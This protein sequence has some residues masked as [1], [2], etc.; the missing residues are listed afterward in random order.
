MLKRVLRH[1]AVR[2]ILC[3]IGAWYIRLVWS[4]GSWIIENDSLPKRMWAEKKPFIMAFWHGHLLLMPCAWQTGR[5]IHMLISRHRDGQMIS[6]TISHFGLQTVS[7]SSGKGGGAAVRQILKALKAGDNAGITPDGPRGPRM[8]AGRGIVDIARLGG[9][10]V[11]P[12]AFSCEKRR[13]LGSWDQF[14]LPLPFSRGIILWGDPID[15]AQDLDPDEL[16]QKRQE[17]ERKMI[18]LA[19]TADMRMGHEPTVPGDVAPDKTEVAA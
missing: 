19:A 8:R 13:I 11:I 5:T 3:W 6:G 12:C 2:I 4:T 14:R 9:V 10:P 7:G 1:N 17:I 18:R 16:E 15:V